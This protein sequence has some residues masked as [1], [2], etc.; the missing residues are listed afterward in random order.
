MIRPYRPDDLDALYEICLHT[1][2]GGRGAAHEFDDPRLLGHAFAAPYAALHP[3]LAFVSADG[4]GVSGYVLGALDTTAFEDRLEREWWPAARE[5]YPLSDNRVVQHIHSPPRTDPALVERFPSHLHVNL[6]ARTRGLGLGGALVDTLL[7]AL[8][9][10]GS[11]GVHLFVRHHNVHA[12][13]FYRHLG[14]TEVDETPEKLAFGM[15]L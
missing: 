15:P 6:L 7:E 2:N 3:E 5:R 10:H 1:G 11:R 8:Q 13:G 9:D 12:I 14:F 4:E